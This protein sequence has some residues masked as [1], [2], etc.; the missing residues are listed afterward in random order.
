MSPSRRVSAAD[1]LRGYIVEAHG[2]RVFHQSVEEE[3]AG[4]GRATIEAEG[5]LVEVGVQVLLADGPVMCAQPPAFEQGGDPVDPREGEMR[6]A[7]TTS[8]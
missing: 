6:R 3:P 1:Q 4:L 5:E 7:P 2:R 8:S